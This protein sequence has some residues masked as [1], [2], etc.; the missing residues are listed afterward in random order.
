M[1]T[2]PA[3]HFDCSPASGR[4]GT[5]G[6]QEEEE[7]SSVC[8]LGMA[9]PAGVG[10]SQTGSAA[11]APFHPAGLAWCVSLGSILFKRINCT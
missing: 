6:V 5:T 11:E 3:M 7:W 2:I 1:Q 8:G 4:G 10:M 9:G